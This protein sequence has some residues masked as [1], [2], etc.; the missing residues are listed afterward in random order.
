MTKPLFDFHLVDVETALKQTGRSWF[1]L[2][3][4][5]YWLNIGDIKLFEQTEEDL[6]LWY[7]ESGRYAVHDY[8]RCIGYQVIRLLEDMIEIMPNIT[9]A[10]PAG[11][12]DLLFQPLDKLRSYN[13][14]WWEN[15]E[16]DENTIV[17]N[18]VTY[19]DVYFMDAHILQLI[20]GELLLFWRHKSNGSDKI[21]IRWDLT[22]DYVFNDEI[23][24]PQ[25]WTATTGIE[26]IDYCKFIKEVYSFN[27]RLMQQMQ[28]RIDKISNSSE[29]QQFYP[30]DYDFD[31]LKTQHRI[32]ENLIKERY[33]DIETKI[34]WED[35][36]KKHRMIGIIK[37]V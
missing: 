3:D 2:T 28:Q 24:R 7:V 19:G 16:D 25:R 11:I 30:A 8:E 17:I 6:K 27:S 18:K 5:F 34:D 14:I 21:Y 4:G 33:E 10:V 1:N 15:F 9:Q 35:M 31:D 13:D 37:S 29:L 26:S 32:F 12:H 36:I 22:N 23:E 20:S